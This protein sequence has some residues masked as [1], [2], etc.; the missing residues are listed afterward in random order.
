[1]ANW[2]VSDP[3]GEKAA[4]AIAG[5]KKQTRAHIVFLLGGNGIDEIIFGH[6][7]LASLIIFMGKMVEVGLDV[8]RELKL[9]RAAHQG[10][11]DGL[12]D[13]G[14]VD[15]Q[16]EPDGAGILRGFWSGCSDCSFN[17]LFQSSSVDGAQDLV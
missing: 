13:A 11:L 16:I 2:L 6:V 12:F 7:Q 8:V 9:V 1:M 4:R 3:A 15:L 10:L 17:R 5:G 14:H